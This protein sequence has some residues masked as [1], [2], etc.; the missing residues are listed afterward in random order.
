MVCINYFLILATNYIG[1]IKI[2]I[3]KKKKNFINLFSGEPFIWAL[4]LLL[5][6]SFRRLRSIVF[7]KILNAPHI[8]VGPNCYIRGVKHINFGENIFIFRGLWLEAINSYRG[9]VFTPDISIGNGVAFSDGVHI[10]CTE[11]I[12]IG[13]NV[14]FGSH[15]FVADHNHGRYSGEAQSSPLEPP[16]DRE[17]AL[18]GP[19]IIEDNVWIGNNVVIL[20]PAKIGAGSILAANSVV[21]GDIPGSTIIGGVPAKPLKEFSSTYCAWIKV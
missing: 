10:S 19:V 7:E 12:I 18:G 17:L 15:I 11:S 4:Y 20:G 3:L 21:S 13:N 9:Q 8:N 2:N 16:A 1:V 14:L 6:I 5:I